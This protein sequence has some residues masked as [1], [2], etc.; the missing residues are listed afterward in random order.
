MTSIFINPKYLHLLTEIFKTYCPNAEIWAFGSRVFG[1]AHEGSDLDL[2]VISLGKT[3]IPLYELRNKIQ[4]SVIP[5]LVD[6]IAFNSIPQSFKDEILRNYAVI[7]NGIDD[8]K[9]T[10]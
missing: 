2:A 6:I 7:Y 4:E 3:S 1:E 9:L 5:F 8:L 10:S